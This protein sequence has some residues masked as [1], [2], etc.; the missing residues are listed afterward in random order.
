MATSESCSRFTAPVRACT[1]HSLKASTTIGFPTAAIKLAE[2]LQARE[3]GGQE[4][5][6]VVNISHVL[7]GHWNS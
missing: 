2:T 6:M 1:A 5:D 4:L 7:S 3:D